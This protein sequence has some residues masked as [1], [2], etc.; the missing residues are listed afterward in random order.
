MADAIGWFFGQVWLGLVN[1]AWA[2][3]HPSA[4]LDWSSPE[5]IV[6]VVYYGASVEF[7]FAVFNTLLVLTLI[8]LWRP[9]FMWG[10]VRVLEGIGN[11]IGRVAAWAA[12]IM[13]LQQIV[14]V[15]VQRIF[16]VSQISLGLG[17][18][19][20]F[21]VSWWA[22][23]LKLYNAMLVV[24]CVSYTF[25]QGGHVRVD[26]LYAGMSFRRKRYTEIFGAVV[27]M[28]PMVVLIWHYAWFFMWRHL[29]VPA[30][31]ATDTFE[32]LEMRAQVLR[33]NVETTGFAPQGF[34]AYFLFKILLVA[35]AALVFLQAVAVIWRAIAELRDG[36]ESADRHLDRDVTGHVA[37]D[38]EHKIHSGA[39]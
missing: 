33:W 38:L 18:V 11:T 23:G 6:R 14:I 2:V 12:L 28:M 1:T 39:T 5:A 29:I 16:A 19:V 34:S 25:I 4:W 17:T 27:F 31:S 13:V 36:P 8:G 22:E 15:F 35:F 24:L 21:D 26:I 32:R 10:G 3:T 37:E 30:P 20:T 7:F 9:G